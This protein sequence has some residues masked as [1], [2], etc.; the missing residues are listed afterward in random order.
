VHRGGIQ[1]SHRG[2]HLEQD[3]RRGSIGRDLLGAQ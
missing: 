1:L 2:L 3:V